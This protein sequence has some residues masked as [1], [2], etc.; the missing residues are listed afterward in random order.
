MSFF[1]ANLLFHCHPWACLW[2]VMCH[3]KKRLWKQPRFARKSN[4]L[5][6]D[7]WRKKNSMLCRN[8]LK[9]RPQEPLSEPRKNGFKPWENCCRPRDL[10]IFV[11]WMIKVANI[12]VFPGVPCCKPYKFQIFWL[13]PAEEIA[14]KNILDDRGKH[15]QPV[16]SLSG[17]MFSFMAQFGVEWSCYLYS[18]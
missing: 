13:L 17:K 12:V 6:L 1:R 11:R 14:K 10:R 8:F 18:I 4:L 9:A 7:C 15:G 5:A 3:W 16:K 2:S